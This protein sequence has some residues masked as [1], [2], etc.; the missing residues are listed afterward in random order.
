MSWVA[1]KGPGPPP[2]NRTDVVWRAGTTAIRDDDGRVRIVAHH[3]TVLAQV[4]EGSTRSWQ[5]AE[6]RRLPVVSGRGRWC[7]LCPIARLTCYLS[8]THLPRCDHAARCRSAGSPTST[9]LSSPIDALSSRTERPSSTVIV[10]SA[11]PAR[12]SAFR[13]APSRARSA[14]NT[15]LPTPPAG[16]PDLRVVCAEPAAHP[17]PTGVLLASP[18]ADSSPSPHRDLSFRPKPQPTSRAVTTDDLELLYV[19]PNRFKIR[20][21]TH[22]MHSEM[23][24]LLLRCAGARDVIGKAQPDAA[25][26]WW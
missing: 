14:V 4:G 17:T 5:S 24:G 18:T 20:C 3:G 7:G 26:Q 6:A 10:R 9:G 13:T 15:R 1:A 12:R 19:P 2:P 21:A 22:L 8:R 11:S 23:L 16:V 25:R